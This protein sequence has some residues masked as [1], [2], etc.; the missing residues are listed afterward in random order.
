MLGAYLIDPGRPAYEIDDLAQE[1]GLEVLPEPAT[2]EETAALVRH[3][4]AARRLAPVL[5]E[6]LRER[7]SEVLYDHIELPLAAVLAARR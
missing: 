1:Y 3:A 7:G 2:D 4:E 5:R 6:R